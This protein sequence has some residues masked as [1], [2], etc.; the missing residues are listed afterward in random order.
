MPHNFLPLLYSGPS[1]QQASEASPSRQHWPTHQNLPQS[2]QSSPQPPQLLALPRQRQ[3][4][5][6]QLPP[7]DTIQPS[8]SPPLQPASRFPNSVSSSPRM[9]VT[10]DWATLL[11]A[12][13][14]SA[15]QPRRRRRA[16]EPSATRQRRRL[17]EESA[18]RCNGEYSE[19]IILRN[20]SFIN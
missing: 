16:M 6:P 8:A 4:M 19:C 2:A 12:E 14:E 3:I 20:D 18:P 5:P 11:R 1:S 10:E 15:E 7:L 17:Y 13:A 9:D